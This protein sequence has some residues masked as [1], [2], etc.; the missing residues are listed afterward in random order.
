MLSR[1]GELYKTDSRFSCSNFTELIDCF[2]AT[3]HARACILRSRVLNTKRRSPAIVL[4][5]QRITNLI[6]YSEY[7]SVIFYIIQGANAQ[8]LQHF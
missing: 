8:K 6:C 1:R 7:I 5:N 2:T 4:K 3:I